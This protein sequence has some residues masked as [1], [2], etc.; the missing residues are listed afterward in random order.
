MGLL[1]TR[2]KIF[3]FREKLDSLP[4]G[5][6]TILPPLNVRIKPTNA[7][8]HNCWYC[9]YRAKNLQLGQDMDLKDSIPREKM[10]EIVDD[11]AEMGVRAV[12]FSGG[13]EPFC[14]PHLPETAERLAERKVKFASLTNG[15][16]LKGRVAEIFARHA[17]W[18]RI[19]MDGWDDASYTA[20]RGCADGE[21]TRIVSNMEKFKKIGGPCY[22]GV[23]IV[24]DT[25]NCDHLYALISRLRE[26]G[27]DSVKVSPCIVSN[28]GTENNEYH[29]PIAASVKEETARARAAFAGRGFEIFDSYHAQ[30]DSFA[31]A[32][33]WCPSLQITPVIGAD[34][35]VY[36]CHDKAY[37]LREGLLGS[38]RDMRFK[39]FWFSDKSTFYCIDPSTACNH[40]CVVDSS[41][42]QIIEYLES[43]PGHLEFV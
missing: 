20:Y 17:T 28:S 29:R 12:T 42:R 10:V 33:R 8:N 4:R 31:K 14:Y 43:D 34:L 32:Y 27:V 18:I 16:R 25:R 23:C 7:C 21:F 5:S 36:P 9:A 41:N 30:L 37:N 15:A 19:S 26:I 1:Y 40:H 11:L 38:I 24:V 2:M 3:H 13:G 35:N 22:L 39:D 6:G